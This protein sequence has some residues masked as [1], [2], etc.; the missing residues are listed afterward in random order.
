MNAKQ[1][2]RNLSLIAVGILPFL[3]VGLGILLLCKGFVFNVLNCFTFFLLP[4]L[5]FGICFLMLRSRWRVW[6]KWLG[7]MLAIAAFAFFTFYLLIL[8]PYIHR[9]YRTGEDALIQCQADWESHDSF[10]YQLTDWGTPTAAEYQFYDKQ[11]GVFFDTYAY[12]LICKYTD[13]DYLAQKAYLEETCRFHTEPL[14][15]PEST[16]TAEYETDGYTFRFLSFDDEEYRLEYPKYMTILGFNDETR[17]IVY[18]YFDDDDL[19]YITS[20]DHF[21]TRDCGWNHI[22]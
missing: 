4:T 16:I 18:L 8:G 22:R 11:M 17:E 19:D 9:T 15:E 21:L 2:R 20:W 3:T 12:T 7:C 5:V 10:F 14:S 1:I 6:L 13:S